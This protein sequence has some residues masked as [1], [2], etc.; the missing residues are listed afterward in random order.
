[1]KTLKEKLTKCNTVNEKN[2]ILYSANLCNANLCNANLCNADLGGADLGG[3]DLGGA[4][5]RGAN[6]C[7]ADLRICGKWGISYKN[8]YLTIGC[9][10]LSLEEWN[11]WFSGIEEFE[12][13]RDTFDFF[14]IEHNF[15]WF[16]RMLLDYPEEFGIEK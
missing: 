1:M 9:K 2:E 15:K 4:N 10:I 6:L 13:K 7:N 5:L 14:E 3:A 12:T 8:N 16:K 11:E